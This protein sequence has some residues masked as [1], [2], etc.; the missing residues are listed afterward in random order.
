MKVIPENLILEKNKTATASA[1]LVLLDIVLNDTGNTTFYL[2]RNNEDIIK[3]IP[4]SGYEFTNSAD[5]WTYTNAVTITPQATSLKIESTGVNPY[6]YCADISLDGAVY[7]KIQ[8]RLK[9]LAGSGWD[10]KVYY[11]TAGH[12]FSSSYYKSFSQ[13]SDFSEYQIVD[14]DMTNLT[15]GD[16]TDYTGNII[17]GLRLDLGSGDGDD[18]E[19]DYIHFMRTYTKFNF[20]LK[21]AVLDSKGTIP[22]LELSVSNINHIL[23]PYLLSLRG[24]V[25][26]SVKITVVNSAYL[27]EDY[28]ELEIIYNVIGTETTQSTVTFRLGAPNPLVQR[29]PLHKYIGLHCGWKYRLSEC[30]YVGKTISGITLSGTSPVSITATS[31][32]YVTD[33]VVEL[34]TCNG[35]T[36]GLEGV[37]TITKT[38][39]NAFTLNG[40]DSSDYGGTYTSGGVA[41]YATCDRTLKQCRQR[42]KQINYG[43]FPGMRSRS[44]RLV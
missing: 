26:S 43:G 5:G 4:L 10:G 37:Y 19:I 27:T 38:N 35:I 29:F 25:G 15:V 11:K 28:S 1:W 16:S 24:G 14:I 44:I 21:P 2:V 32:G 7:N 18:F 40:T 31:H 42:G 12:T 23:Q 22:I 34:F 9:R 17:T 33:D 39:D 41:G 6:F 13:P 3:P 20:D 8:I 36:G 30:G